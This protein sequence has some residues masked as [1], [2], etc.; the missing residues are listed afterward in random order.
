MKKVYI[1]I[2]IAS[3]IFGASNQLLAGKNVFKVLALKGNVM[4]NRAGTNSWDKLKSNASITDDQNIKLDDGAYLGLVH[5]GGRTVEL[6]NSGTYS[7]AA[8]SKDIKSKK[9]D[10]SKRLTKYVTEQISSAD[11]LLSGSDYRNSMKIT[12]SV[13]RGI[14]SEGQTNY[15]DAAGSRQDD[16][17][18][19][20]NIIIVKS[21]RKTNI[22]N[23]IVTF[24]WHPLP[25]VKDYAISLHDRFDREI[26]TKTVSDTTISINLYD[27][28]LEKN[29][30]YFWNV[31]SANNKKIKSEDCAFLILPDEKVSAMNEDLSVIR[32]DYL[33]DNSSL[34][35]IILATFYQENNLNID[36]MNSYEEAIKQSP[37]VDEFKKLYDIFLYKLKTGN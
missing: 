9:D 29:V 7:A 20:N 37:D 4:I 10:L 28:N 15:K 11:D 13:E 32:D 12:G 26:L 3:L 31:S 1:L 14:T 23:S 6:K 16:I 2:L 17:L 25:D 5:D 19:N 22:L 35:K 27:F 21:P 18:N 30:Y 33:K 34:G 24:Q 8:L 36:A